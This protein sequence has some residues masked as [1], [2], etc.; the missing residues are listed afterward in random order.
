MKRRKFELSERAKRKRKN[1][2]EK[3]RDREREE[4]PRLIVDNFVL[5][6]PLI[7]KR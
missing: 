2:I 4:I 1:G 7:I 5:R 6:N 3:E